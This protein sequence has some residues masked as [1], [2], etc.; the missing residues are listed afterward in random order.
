M[1]DPLTTP[2][3]TAAAA[4]VSAAPDRPPRY[5]TVQPDPQPGQPPP[6]RR[7]V[8]ADGRPLGSVPGRAPLLRLF[9]T[10]YL[11][12]LGARKTEQA[13][14]EAGVRRPR[15]PKPPPDP[16]APVFTPEQLQ[17]ARKELGNISQRDLA[18]LLGTN[19][20]QLDGAEHGRRH[21]SSHAARKLAALLAERRARWGA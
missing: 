9:T 16:D 6:L 1:I 15:Q 14:R 11:A 20:G 4:A 21:L 10:D 17:E 7:V 13:L 19:R 2:V 18:P 12:Q 5:L 3:L 8:R